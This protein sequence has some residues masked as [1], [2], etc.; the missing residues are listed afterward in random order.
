MMATRELTRS[1][2]ILPLYLRTAA[3]L[4][5]G[6]ARLPGVPGGGGDVPDLE[7]VLRNVAV[8]PGQLDRYSAVC[9]WPQAA[10]VPSTYVHTLAFGLH[11]AL[12][13]DGS[14]PFAAIGLVHVEN[15]IVQLRPLTA[16]ERL[17][18]SVHATTPE[19]HPR[20]RTFAIITT[21]HCDG[22]LVWSERST[23]L[24]RGGGGTPNQP[25]G[26]SPGGAPVTA[27]AD[28]TAVAREQWQVPE[29]IG[30]RYAAVSGDRN[31]IHLHALSAKAFGFPR[32]IAHGMWTK[33]RCLS[34]LAGDLP[35][36]YAITVSFRKPV[37]LPSSVAFEAHTEG[38]AIQLA[39]RGVKRDELH[40][41]GQ[42]RTTAID[43]ATAPSRPSKKPTG[44]LPRPA[45]GARP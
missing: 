39:L 15:E 31:P 44:A 40:L 10:T 25:P 12:M 19:P 34:A 33:A 18:F 36:A 28:A 37:L 21:G 23:M 4:V 32:A 8:D 30:R 9:Q 17:T 1:P 16:G 38:D 20:G 29:D 11:M 41:E 35:D 42:V 7:L 43:G 45:A 26:T 5:P 22:E 13:T 3:T 27:D 6:T 2:S 14:F 24:R